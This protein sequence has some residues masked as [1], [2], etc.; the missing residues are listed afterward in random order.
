[1]MM[2]LISIASAILNER[3]NAS[4]KTTKIPIS[5]NTP[6]MMLEVTSR[7]I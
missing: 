5:N 3:E 2:R 4:P 6:V 7:A 1:M